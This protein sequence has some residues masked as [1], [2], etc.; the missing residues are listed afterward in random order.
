MKLRSFMGAIT[1]G[2]LAA[3]TL[4]GCS[5]AP[6]QN[7]ST[8]LKVGWHTGGDL[9]A[10][11][12]IITRFEELHPDV[13][14]KLSTADDATYAQTLKTQLV[15]GTAPD[16][17]MVWP[18]LGSS[19]DT[20][21][22]P[23]DGYLADLSDT[24]WAKTATD[25]AVEAASDKGKVWMVTPGVGTIGAIYNEDALES[26]GLSIPT[27]WN[28]LLQFCT[29]AK[30]EGKIAFGL[31]L[32]ETWM[33]QLI[34]MSFVAD[35]I[36]NTAT[37][38]S[39]LEDGTFNFADSSEW[40]TAFEKHIEMTEAGCFNESP[41]GTSRNSI[42]P[43]VIDGSYLGMVSVGVDLANL[44]DSKTGNPDGRFTI[45]ALPASEVESD[46]RMIALYNN[47]I[48]INS[49]T[50]HMDVAR[51]FV[52]L[53]SSEW[54]LN[55]FATAASLIPTVTIDD[56][57][58]PASLTHVLEFSTA[59]RLAGGSWTPGAETQSAFINGV[60]A[61]LLNKQTIQ[62]TLEQMQD[63]YTAFLEAR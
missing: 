19:G 12:A 11:E 23:R 31:G 46:Q 51:E 5:V 52:D 54:G 29:D 2:T 27:T 61:I 37:F 58:P 8:V 39:A 40:R 30:A 42:L 53:F 48:A 34:P 7:G 33:S 15:A 45:T 28:Q 4:S 44:T 32:Q 9:Q 20:S 36:P 18:Y 1:V 57:E 47:G 35:L 17:M 16:L 38:N 49:N 24:E 10:V 50:P 41:L 3:A 13:T 22:L 21:S 62:Q 59:G 63:G 14:V 56:F 25:G 60:Q 26:V 6:P 55:E 43:G